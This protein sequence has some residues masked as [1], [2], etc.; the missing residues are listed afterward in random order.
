MEKHYFLE[1]S[2]PHAALIDINKVNKAITTLKLNYDSLHDCY[3]IGLH[4]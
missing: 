1:N 4:F 2:S 3:P